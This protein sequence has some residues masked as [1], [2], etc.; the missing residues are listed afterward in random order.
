MEETTISDFHQDFD[1][2]VEALT[3]SEER[4]LAGMLALEIMHEIRNPLEALGYLTY[5]CNQEADDSQKVREYMRLAEEQVSTVDRIVHQTLGFAKSHEVAEPVELATIAEAALRIHQRTID[6]KNLRL[7]KDLRPDAIAPVAR[8]DLL[9]VFSNLIVNAVDALPEDGVLRLRV[10]KCCSEVQL[11]IADNGHGIPREH[12]DKIFR[13]FFTT[14]QGRGNGL[15]LALSK[16]IIDRY[17]GRIRMRS[18]V[19]PGKSGTTF[20]I[21]LPLGTLEHS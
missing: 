20:R 6:T 4:A 2:M 11:I 19:R 1:P 17:R 21:S 3:L 14:K 13:P 15:G 8:G 16:R 12:S 9:Q 7:I 18:S 10:R 5:L